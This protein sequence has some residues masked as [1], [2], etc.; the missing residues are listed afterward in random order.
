LEAAPAHASIEHAIAKLALRDPPGGTHSSASPGPRS[1]FVAAVRYRL[2]SRRR[3]GRPHSQLATRNPDLDLDPV[4][5]RERRQQRRAI[6]LEASDQPRPL[7]IACQLRLG[8]VALSGQQTVDRQPVVVEQHQRRGLVEHHVVA[9]RTV[10]EL[11]EPVG[12]GCRNG[13]AMNLRSFA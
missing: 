9:G 6:E 12:S 10:A 11:V 5:E 8:P 13:I 4:A 3:Q 1:E 2:G 7:V